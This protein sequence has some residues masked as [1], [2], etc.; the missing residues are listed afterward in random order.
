MASVGGGVGH[1]AQAC[2]GDTA[3]VGLCRRM[4]RLRL[5]ASDPWEEHVQ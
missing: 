5:S 4:P 2:G 1:V 3:I